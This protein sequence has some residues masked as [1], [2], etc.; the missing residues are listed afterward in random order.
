MALSQSLPTPKTHELFR[1]VTN[2]AVGAPLAALPVPVA[3]TTPDGSTPV[4]VTTVIDAGSLIERV[5][6]TDTFVNTADANARQISE[7]PLCTLVR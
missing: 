7:V 2:P 5:A 3:P 6:L 1:V 4:K